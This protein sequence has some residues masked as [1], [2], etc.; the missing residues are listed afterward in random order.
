MRKILNSRKHYKYD[1]FL[2]SMR[3]FKMKNKI[4]VIDIE[5]I[6]DKIEI[7]HTERNFLNSSLNKI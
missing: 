1:E 5:Q 7:N 2:Q 6:I 4:I 3:D